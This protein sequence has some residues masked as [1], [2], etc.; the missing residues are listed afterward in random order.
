MNI[1]EFQPY[2]RINITESLIIEE[3]DKDIR[4][5]IEAINMFKNIKRLKLNYTIFDPEFA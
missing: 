3:Y 2:Y 5:L 1:K 4:L